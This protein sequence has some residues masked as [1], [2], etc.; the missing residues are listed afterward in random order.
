MRCLI[1]SQ[2]ATPPRAGQHPSH[3]LQGS[4]PRLAILLKIE[5]IPSVQFAVIRCGFRGCRLA[6]RQL[7]SGARKRP[8][9]A[10]RVVAPLYLYR[11]RNV[12][13]R[14]AFLTKLRSSHDIPNNISDI[15]MRHTLNSPLHINTEHLRSARFLCRFAASSS[16]DRF[17]PLGSECAAWQPFAGH[18]SDSGPH[19]TPKDCRPHN[20]PWEFEPLARTAPAKVRRCYC[21]RSM[22]LE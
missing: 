17:I 10:I 13:P 11:L 18:R 5:L 4:A 16:S 22:P 2:Q 21:G 12:D 6:G 3:A 1:D 7:N 8:H 9:D 14:L 15:A 19:A 20:M